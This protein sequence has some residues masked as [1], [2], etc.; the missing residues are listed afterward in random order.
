[1]ENFAQK[2]KEQE[3]QRRMYTRSDYRV[4]TD[5]LIRNWEQV[6]RGAKTRGTADVTSLGPEIHEQN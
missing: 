5:E 3:Q 1:M 4:W 6:G 2:L